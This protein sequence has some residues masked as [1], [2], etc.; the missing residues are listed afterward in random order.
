MNKRSSVTRWAFRKYCS[1]GKSYFPLYILFLLMVEIG[2]V[3]FNLWMSAKLVNA[4]VY[5][6]GSFSVWLLVCILLA[7]NLFSGFLRG[8]LS[9]TL[10]VKARSIA[11]NEQK[12]LLEKTL[13]LPYLLM[14]DPNVR[15]LRS[16]IDSDARVYGFGTQYLRRKSE[17]RIR[18]IVHLALSSILSMELVFG[19]AQSGFLR[20]SLFPLFVLIVMAVLQVLLISGGTKL[21]E[22]P[23]MNMSADMLENDRLLRAV[24]KDGK[25]NRL[26]GI[27]P[28]FAEKIDAT[29]KKTGHSIRRYFGLLSYV[30]SSQKV[31]QYLAVAASW[32]FVAWY[33]IRGTL[34]VG[35]VIKYAGYLLNLV[36]NAG[37]LLS[38][39]PEFRQNEP[40]L[41]SYRRFFELPE[42]KTK[43]TQLPENRDEGNVLE[44]CH[45]T[46]TYPGKTEPAL[47]DVSFRLEDGEK[48]AIV[49]RN[50]S[51][52]ST[53]I[54]LLCGLYEPDT[55]CILWNGTDIRLFDKQAYR[56]MFSVVFQDFRLLAIS[57]EDNMSVVQMADR[58]KSE[59]ALDKAGILDRIRGMPDGTNTILYKEYDA[60]GV[61]ISGG[62]A[63]KLALARA[64][65]HDG[66]YMILDE[67]TA[68]LDPIAESEVYQRFNKILEG[69]TAVYISHR[70]SSCR[71]CQRILVMKDGNVSQIG[72]HEELVAQK[73]GEYASLWTAQAKHYDAQS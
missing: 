18:C 31:F 26:Y 17:A 34:E 47:S 16:R 27:T 36:Q 40:Y 3:Y 1:Y 33:A 49:G 73:D 52:K 6:E 2:P 22:K 28:L 51:G 14:E 29:N 50:G 71:F 7:G 55:G 67:P 8:L 21:V 45:V 46:F 48:L 68:A 30:M 10:Q 64:L 54:K 32:I 13:S 35:N 25:E 41:E 12:A 58:T 59:Q 70:L 11:A 39:I 66:R 44:F 38:T 56:R 4:L 53:L 15:E 63:Q 65:A 61:E 69:K 42:D 24:S 57:V 60:D 19:I 20:E 43:G 9:Q 62:E 72:S 37:W 23:K 5:Y